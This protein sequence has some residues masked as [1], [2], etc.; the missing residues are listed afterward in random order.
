[1]S[2]RNMEDRVDLLFIL[3][4]IITKSLTYFNLNVSCN[5]L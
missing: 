1:M 3:S 5:G 4:K 2:V